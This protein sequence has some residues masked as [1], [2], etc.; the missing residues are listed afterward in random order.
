MSFESGSALL[1]DRLHALFPR[2]TAPD[3]A[4]YVEPLGAALAEFSITTPIRIAAFLAQVGHESAGLTRWAENLRYR[5]DTLAKLFP[6][7]CR[8][9]HGNPTQRGIEAARSGPEAVAELIYDDRDD[10]GNI[11]PGDGWRFRGR[12]PIQITG[13]SNYQRTGELL[14]VDLLKAPELLETP[15]YGFR[16]AGLY[17]LT[18]GLNDLADR[19]TEGAFRIITRRINGGYVGWEDRFKRWRE[20]RAVFGLPP[21]AEKGTA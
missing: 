3:L 15:E 2:L 18:R 4:G 17:W 19:D 8:D 1:K 9:S 7:R 6:G 12:G 5:P 11:E 10:L 13:R 20:A 14:G 16:A 21:L